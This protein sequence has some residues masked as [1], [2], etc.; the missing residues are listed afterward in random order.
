[1]TAAAVLVTAAVAARVTWELLGPLV[2]LLA[3]TIGLCVIGLVTF[4]GFRR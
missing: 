1:M 4:G 2:P 3:V